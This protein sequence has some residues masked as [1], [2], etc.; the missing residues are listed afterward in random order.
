[1]I[2]FKLYSLI[3]SEPHDLLFQHA[4]KI[5]DFSSSLSEAPHFFVILAKAGIHGFGQ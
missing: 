2:L 3:S 1:M 5:M 4:S